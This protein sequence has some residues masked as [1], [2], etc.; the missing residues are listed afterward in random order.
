M[1]DGG[2][3]SGFSGPI[4]NRIRDN[5]RRRPI[6][7]G[8]TNGHQEPQVLGVYPHQIVGNAD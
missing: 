2:H 3:I 7:S 5:I 4:R 8:H 6:G 1:Q